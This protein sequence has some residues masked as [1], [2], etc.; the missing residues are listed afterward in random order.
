M[1]YVIYS[2]KMAG[3]RDDPLLKNVCGGSYRTTPAPK[4]MTNNSFRNTKKHANSVIKL[5]KEKKIKVPRE[6][7]ALETCL[8]FH[9]RLKSCNV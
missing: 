4:K 6:S 7:N 5:R 3:M 8:G 2:R 9:F 1:K